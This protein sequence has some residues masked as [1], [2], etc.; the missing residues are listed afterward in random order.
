MDRDYPEPSPFSAVCQWLISL[1]RLLRTES[2]AKLVRAARAQAF[3]PGNNFTC[4]RSKS[5]IHSRT[6]ADLSV[7]IHSALVIRSEDI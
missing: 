6:L 5:T 7:A 2:E 4:S 1:I 3:N